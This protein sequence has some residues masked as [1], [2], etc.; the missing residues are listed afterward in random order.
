MYGG[1]GAGKPKASASAMRPQTAYREPLLVAALSLKGGTGKTTAALNLAPLLAA[2]GQ[3]AIIVDFD[4]HHGAWRWAQ[5]TLGGLHGFEPR[6]DVLTAPTAREGLAET[7]REM[8][9][10]AGARMILLDCPPALDMAAETAAAVSNLILVPCSTSPMEI[11]AAE[12][13]VTLA[14]A[15]R[16][17]G[18]ANGPLLSLIPSK[19]PAGVTAAATMRGGLALLGEPVGPTIGQHAMVVKAAMAGRMVAD[20]APGSPAAHDY[21]RLAGHVLERLSLTNSSMDN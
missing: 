19:M 7:L 12:M 14:A 17:K 9:R 20:Y 10:R 11:W 4:P 21:E 8:A 5:Q 18:G 16:Q 2:R 13:A 15:A 3:R 1:E 6:R